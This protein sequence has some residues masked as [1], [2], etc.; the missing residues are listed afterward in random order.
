MFAKYPFDF[1]ILSLHQ[2][3][4]LEIWCND[5]QNGKSW[6]EY[7]ERYYK[8]MFALVQN[9]KNYSVLG[10]IDFITRYD[11]TGIYPF[12]EIRTIREE[13]LKT[14]EKRLLYHRH[15]RQETP[16]SYAEPE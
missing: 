15:L 16:N 12:E 6:Q 1:I 3:E 14:G 2:V 8:E 4:D 9:Y 13:I 11:E 5:F 10:H 7:N